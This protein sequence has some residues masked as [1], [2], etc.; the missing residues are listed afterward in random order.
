MAPNLGFGLY[1]HWPFCQSKCPYCDFN[2]HVETRIDQK[3]WQQA[4]L[5]E[6]ARCGA[7]TS[8]RILDSVYFGGGTPSLMDPDL[9]ALILDKVRQT[10][11]QSNDIEITLEANPSSVEAGRFAGFR[12]AG[13]NRVSIGVQALQDADLQRLGRLHTVHDA[14]VAIDVATTLFPRV[15]FDLIY[16]RQHQSLK[17]WRSELQLA[18]SL[19][20]SH[21]SL[22][23]LTIEEDTVFHARHTRGLLLGL[24]QEDLAADMFDLTQELCNA[25]GIPSYEVSNHAHMGQESRHNLIYWRG[26]DYAGIGPG[27]HGRLFNGGHRVA[28]EGI[29]TPGAWLQGVERRANGE[30]SRT[31]MLPTDAGAEYMMMGLRVKEGIRPSHYRRLTGLDLPQDKIQGLIRLKL[32]IEGQDSLRAT[33]SGM[34]VL[35]AILR[36]VLA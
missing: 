10:W 16:A 17:D 23:Q 9:V 30:L 32:L 33:Q 22:Y 27:A 12:S 34:L 13:I 36:D 35:N 26:G 6:I 2:S 3:R 5:A 29:K 28:T 4:Y 31:S 7:E 21:M 18:L 8:G 11:R 25:A 14:L 15:N 19:G 20:T 1:V 24:P